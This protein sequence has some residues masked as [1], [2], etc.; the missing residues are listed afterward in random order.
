[1]RAGTKLAGIPLLGALAMS[2]AWP[3]APVHAKP[4]LRQ[5]IKRQLSRDAYVHFGTLI[6]ALGVT[7][8]MTVLDI[9][10]G[11]GYASFLFAERLR[12]TGAVYAA[13]I[14]ADFVG[15]IADEA[16]R[17]GLGNLHAVAVREEGLDDFYGTHRYDLVLLSNV[18][19]CLGDRVA[20]FRALR[21]F[22]NPGARLALVLYN[23]APLF[24]VDDLSDVDGLVET[25]AED[26]E[27][28][29]FYRRLSPA[30]RRLVDGKARGDDVA[31][32][33][34]DDFNRMLADPR[35]YEEFYRASYFANDLFTPPE[36]DFANWLLMT[37]AED[38]V[39]ER[40][41]VR[42][43]ARAMRAVVRLN[44][45]FFAARLGDFLA[46]DGLGAYLPAGDANRHTSKYV[47][48]RELDAAGYRFVREMTLSPYFDAVIMAPKAP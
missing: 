4:P 37:L 11:P 20:Y 18:Y 14:R 10:A 24:S 30:T 32:A 5:A 15:H 12:G 43:D 7:P 2:I 17:R 23:Q 27:G 38:G 34:V 36:R 8:G 35:F 1:M 48:L 45:L 16:K 28:E 9:G 25:L 42:P 39:P 44:R 6:D 31:K 21:G 40:P 47:A 41:G 22:L 33:L 46:T 19:H 26:V 13:D 29:P 3:A